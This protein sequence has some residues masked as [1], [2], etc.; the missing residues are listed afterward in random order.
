MA[1]LTPIEDLSVHGLVQRVEECER[2]KAQGW[3]P[4]EDQTAVLETEAPCKKAIAERLDNLEGGLTSYEK[5]AAKSFLDKAIAAVKE[6]DSSAACQKRKAKLEELL[7]AAQ[8]AS[9][10]DEPSH[11]KK[12]KDAAKR[13]EKEYEDAHKIYEKWEK[14]KQMYKSVDELNAMKKRHADAEKGREITKEFIA[15]QLCLKKGTGAGP[16][17][18]GPSVVSKVA[19][20]KPKTT[21]VRINPGVRPAPGG[22]P[23]AKASAPPGPS[24]AQLRSA[25]LVSE[26]RREA[27]EAE[28]ARFQAQEAPAPP[29]RPRN[30]PKQKEEPLVVLSYKCTVKAVAEHLKISE[31]EARG[32]AASSAEFKS[33]LDSEAWQWVQERSL[34]IEA[35]EKQKERDKE[36]QKS[37]NALAR[38]A[39]KA[40]P[41]FVPPAS[42]APAVRPGQTSAAVNKA[43]GGYAA[44]PAKAKPKGAVG[45]ALAAG[46][47]M[48]KAKSI[49]THKT[50]FSALADDDDSDDGFTAVPSRRR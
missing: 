16:A 19:A 38:A 32:L 27:E 50:A 34:K 47:S 31:N 44:A 23:A 20:P 21:T 43:S 24:N 15:Q 40:A 8:N 18:S 30:P 22:Y 7:A 3:S 9:S 13:A 48:P 41:Q 33:N 17:W 26:L 45:K 10:A 28:A 1:S 25:Q 37:A 46:A 4:D 35:A 12:A 6:G 14:G 11:V 42:S 49:A 29:P 39:E 2:I 5:S 36:K